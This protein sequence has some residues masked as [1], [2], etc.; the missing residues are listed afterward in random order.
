[1]GGTVLLRS[2][3]RS[4]WM[5][6]GMQLVATR[7]PPR[8]ACSRACVRRG[9]GRRN[10]MVRTPFV[11]GD[12]HRCESRFGLRDGTTRQVSE[13]RQLGARNGTDG[14]CAHVPATRRRTILPISS[15]ISD[16]G[17]FRRRPPNASTSWKRHHVV[18][19]VDLPFSIPRT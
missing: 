3:R 10:R 8:R 2:S 9:S 13:T 12:K 6:D 11:H 16:E 4:S 18:G 5:T 1:M 17:L 7:P 15:T 14:S 19:C